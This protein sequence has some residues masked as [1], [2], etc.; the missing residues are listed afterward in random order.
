MGERLKVIRFLK[1][2]YWWVLERSEQVGEI[3]ITKI[4]NGRNNKCESLYISLT[5]R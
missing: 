1:N 5:S 3:I 2:R 4:Q